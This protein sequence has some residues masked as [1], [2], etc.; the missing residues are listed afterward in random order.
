MHAR[1]HARA[2]RYIAA[3]AIIAIVI[4]MIPIIQLIP[5]SRQHVNRLTAA[6][7]K[8]FLMIWTHT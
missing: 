2:P 5:D 7:C 4:G 8:S 1:T 3:L 6:S